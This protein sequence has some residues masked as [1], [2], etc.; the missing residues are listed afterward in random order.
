[1]AFR[2]R[3]WYKTCAQT[4][5]FSSWSAVWHLNEAMELNLSVV[6]VFRKS[7]NSIYMLSFSIEHNLCWEN[8]SL[9][10]SQMWFCRNPGF[11]FLFLLMGICEESFMYCSGHL[12]SY[13]KWFNFHL[14]RIITW[15]S[16]IT[17]RVQSQLICN[18]L[19]GLLL[20]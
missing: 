12:N 9:S 7:I 16:C 2:W 18:S 6:T 13:Q 4:N 11:P 10:S 19:I 8:L 17:L 20:V 5:H 3:S 1:M 14:N 15:Q